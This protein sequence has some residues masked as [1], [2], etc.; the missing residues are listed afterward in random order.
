VE[1]KPA[2][3]PLTGFIAPKS[4]PASYP[5]PKRGEVV[6]RQYRWPRTLNTYLCYPRELETQDLS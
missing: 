3:I 2:G 1:D 6:K 4:I 5:P